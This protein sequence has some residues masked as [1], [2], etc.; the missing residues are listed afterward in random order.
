MVSEDE[1][2]VV[3]FAEEGAG[4]EMTEHEERH[5]GHR[6]QCRIHLTRKSRLR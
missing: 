6:K 5:N 2:S 3:G 4:M 1:E